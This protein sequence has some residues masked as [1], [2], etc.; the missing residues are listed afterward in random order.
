MLKAQMLSA[1]CVPAKGCVL[2]Y[3]PPTV[4]ARPQRRRAAADARPQTRGRTRVALEA[5]PQ[6]RG[7]KSAARRV[8]SFATR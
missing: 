4:G 2:G 6:E 8:S 3:L 7:H 1:H 5:R